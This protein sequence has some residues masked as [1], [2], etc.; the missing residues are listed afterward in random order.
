ML[1][2]RGGSKDAV[3]MRQLA[4]STGKLKN[5]RSAADTDLLSVLSV[6]RLRI[7]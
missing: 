6:W 5:S 7:L 1:A 4:W 2:N 3:T